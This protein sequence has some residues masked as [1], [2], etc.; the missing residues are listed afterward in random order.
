MEEHLIV[1]EMNRKLTLIELLVV[2]AIIGILMSLL[3][4]P[5]GKARK[6]AK[7]SVCI[8]NPKQIGIGFASYPTDYE[9]FPV[10]KNDWGGNLSYD[11]LINIDYRLIIA[12]DIDSSTFRSPI[13][14]CPDD[15]TNNGNKAGR[16]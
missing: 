2:I 14:E 15:E 8:A 6:K 7:Q 11:D 1:R 3:M 4:P 16:S 12:N 10:F 9:N 13:F 5:L